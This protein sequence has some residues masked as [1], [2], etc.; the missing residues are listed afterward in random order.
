MSLLITSSVPPSLGS[1]DPFTGPA[2]L[3][4]AYPQPNLRLLNDLGSPRSLNHGKFSEALMDR[5]IPL[6]RSWNRRTKAAILQILGP[7][8]SCPREGSRAGRIVGLSIQARRFQP[9]ESGSLVRMGVSVI[10]LMGRITEI[11]IH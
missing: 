1:W 11:L 3:D 8:H 5:K 7:G 6:P 2:I 10:S 4:T 9:R